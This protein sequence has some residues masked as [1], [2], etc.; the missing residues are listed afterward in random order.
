[1]KVYF[2]RHGETGH[3]VLNIRQDHTVELS[4]RGLK[5]AG[6]LTKRFLKIPVDV[7]FSSPMKRAKHTAE[8]INKKLKKEI[9]YSDLIQEWKRPS[10]FVGKKRDDPASLELHKILNA[11]QN[12]PDWHYSDEENFI[13]F[14]NRVKKFLDFLTIEARQENILVVSHGGTIKMIALLMALGNMVTPEI[15]YSFTDTF[16]IY[17][18]SI[19]LCEKKDNVWSIE[20]FNDSRHL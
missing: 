1:M 17:N 3:N 9:V 5:Q 15:F 13:D 11:H 2:V 16:R 19:T 14:K 4:E 18:T 7:I 6:V 10:E 20:A 8:I 12:D